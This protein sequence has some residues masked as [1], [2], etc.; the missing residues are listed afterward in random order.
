MIGSFGQASRRRAVLCSMGIVCIILAGCSQTFRQIAIPLPTQT[1]DPA[2]LNRALFATTDG[3]SRPGAVTFVDVSGDTNVGQVRVGNNPVQIGLT[4]G[5]GRAITPNTGDNTASSFQ[6]GVT[7]PTVNATSLP[8]SANAVFAHSRQNGKFYIALSGP[9]HNSLGVVDSTLALVKEVALG[10]CSNPVAISQVPGPGSVYVACK[11]SGEVAEV[12]PNDNVFLKTI[13]VGSSPVWLDTSSD[14]KYTF[15]AN[16]GSSTVSVICSSTD[17]TVCVGDTVVQT[18]PVGGAPNFLKYDVHSQ[19]V[20]VGGA[21]FI[22]IIDTSGIQPAPPAGTT[23]TVTDITTFS[24]NAWATALQ[25]GTRFY[26]SDSG[27]KTVTVFN[28]NNLSVIKTIKLADPLTPIS[29]PANTTPIMID[30]DKNSI[31]VYT[32]TTGSNDISIIRTSDDTEVFPGSTAGGG[33]GRITAP[34]VGVACT[35]GTPIGNNCRQT[36]TYILVL[37]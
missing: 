36:P 27:A 1:G 30:S 19:R 12:T 34:L 9:T 10:T 17:V 26:V 5:G 13:G 7:N 22:S 6:T 32:A 29:T 21:G 23:F 33:S 15:V 8:A 3:A 25:D 35:V 24:G 37:P 4:F 20:Y 14:G 28:A 31:K 2:P 18:I 11:G 16:Q